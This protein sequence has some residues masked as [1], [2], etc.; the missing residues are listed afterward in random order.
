MSSIEPIT[1]ECSEW[2]I[3]LKKQIHA[4]QQ[5]AALAVNHELERLYWN[6]GD[7]ITSRKKQH[8]WGS[9]VIKQVS[10]DLQ[11]EFPRIKGF[12]VRNLDYMCLFASSWTWEEIRKRH[13]RNYLGII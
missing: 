8:G 9:K 7:S 2:L 5:R 4:A 1:Q 12:S 6:I 3:S 10:E 13:L 11:R